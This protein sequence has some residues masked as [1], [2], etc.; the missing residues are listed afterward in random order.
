MQRKKEKEARRKQH[1]ACGVV[2]DPSKRR[3]P[4]AP[5]AAKPSRP[6]SLPWSSTGSLIHVWQPARAAVLGLL[7]G[8]HSTALP[9]HPLLACTHCSDLPELFVDWEGLLRIYKELRSH[10]SS[11]AP[12]ANT[13]VNLSVNR[14]A[15][16]GREGLKTPNN[17]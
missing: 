9:R 7:A 4:E 15:L 2:W 17:D 1:P 3:K 11:Q 5:A 12:R 16:E 8:S 14:Q 10:F 6:L 13:D